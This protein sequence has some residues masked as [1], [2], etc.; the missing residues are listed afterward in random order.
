M[1]HA[2]DPVAIIEGHQLDDDACC[3]VCGFD[4]AEWYWWR[5]STDEGRALMTPIP[6]C[7]TKS[8]GK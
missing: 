1:N 3:I 7:I 2:S 4:A 5:Y 8:D 6:F